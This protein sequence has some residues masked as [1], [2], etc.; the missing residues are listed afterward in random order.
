MDVRIT[1]DET[2]AMNEK[3]GDV[4]GGERREKRWRCIR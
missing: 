4:L 3:V 1:S 2:R